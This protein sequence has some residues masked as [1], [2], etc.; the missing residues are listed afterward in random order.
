MN[1]WALLLSFFSS[2]TTP[3]FC[4]NVAEVKTVQTHQP[5]QVIVLMSTDR[6][7]SK[8]N[9]VAEN[10]MHAYQQAG[11]NA[12]LYRVTDFGH[13]F[14]QP[15]AYMQK[16]EAFMKFNDAVLAANLVVLVTPEYNAT[17][18][19]PLTR[20]LNLLSFPSSFND[21]KYVIVSL[22]VSPY[23]AVRAYEGLKKVLTDLHAVVLN[24]LAVKIPE[25]QNATKSSSVY[26]EHA[27]K[28]TEFLQ[29]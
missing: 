29:K 23:G 2:L 17:I 8:T 26:K 7:D 15:T 12:E 5:A 21:K 24:D 27:L 3:G 19:A 22:S 9:Y 10:L 13:E 14:Y 20:V 6:P 4:A 28:I 11:L 18:P 1:A 16:P 25:V